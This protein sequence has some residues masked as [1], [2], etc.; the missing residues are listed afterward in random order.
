MQKTGFQVGKLE[1]NQNNEGGKI[2]CTNSDEKI[3]AEQKLDYTNFPL[4]E[5][6][7]FWK[8]GEVILLPSEY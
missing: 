3:L 2:I 4:P 6:I 8:E 5:G 7:T 1:L